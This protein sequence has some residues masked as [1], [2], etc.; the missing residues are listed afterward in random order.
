MSKGVSFVFTRTADQKKAVKSA[1]TDQNIEQAKNEEY[2]EIV[3]TGSE[4]IGDEKRPVVKEEKLVI[5]LIP[6]KEIFSKKPGE[7]VINK[8]IKSEPEGAEEQLSLEERA[9]REL[10]TDAEKSGEDI[11]RE[12]EEKERRSMI[13]PFGEKNDE[14]LDVTEQPDKPTNEDYEQVPVG[15]FGEAMLRGMGWDEG[16]NIGNKNSGVIKPIEVSFRPKGL[17]LGALPKKKEKQKDK[18]GKEEEKLEIVK[19][20]YVLVI[21]GSN[22][23][24]YGQIESIDENTG[25]V[26]VKLTLQNQVVNLSENLIQPVSSEDYRKS[27]RV[28]NKDKYEEHKIKQEKTEKRREEEMSERKRERRRTRS[29]SKDRKREDSGSRRKRSRDRSSS[30][31][32]R[33]L[34]VRPLLKVR[35]IDPE[36]KKGYYFRKKMVVIDVVSYDIVVCKSEDGKLLEDI[37]P[38]RLESVIPKESPAYVMIVRGK[39]AGKVAEIRARDKRQCLATVEILPDREK[40]L[41][42]SYDSI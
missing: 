33:K 20:K 9:R 13:I 29:R 15:A 1:F 31:E 3:Y 11:S 41:E 37:H 40:V 30:R 36:Y 28:L 34:W 39:Q 27:F 16:R 18:G 17:G 24:L 32:L 19:G 6:N 35:C 8:E 22:K 26:Y 25:R 23:G 7:D 2:E 5:P 10:L 12:R 42:L 4:K 14:I 38:S 21:G